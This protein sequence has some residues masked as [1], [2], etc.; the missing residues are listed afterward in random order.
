MTSFTM[1]PL[2][3][4]KRGAP[5][6]VA[7]R[8]VAIRSGTVNRVRGYHFPLY[9]GRSSRILVDSGRRDPVPAGARPDGRCER[10]GLSPPGAPLRGRA[11]LLGDG[12]L[13]RDRVPEREDVGLA[14]GAARGASAGDP[15]LRLAAGRD[16]RSRPDG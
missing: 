11:R 12:K 15:D 9:A 2:L 16:G 7:A 10:P 1:S 14:E 6:A 3:T 13:W 5:G 8:I 4:K